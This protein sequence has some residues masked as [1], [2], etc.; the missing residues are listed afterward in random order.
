MEY[1]NITLNFWYHNQNTIITT[2]ITI[3]LP[4]L[5]ALIIYLIKRG[6]TKNLIKKLLKED[7]DDLKKYLQS[8]KEI[9][10]LKNTPTDD[11][12]STSN[13]INLITMIFE[14]KLN[15]IDLIK[16]L[17]KYKVN[18][19]KLLET[20]YLLLDK[21]VKEKLEGNIININQSLNLLNEIKPS[22]TFEKYIRQDIKGINQDVENV[23][24]LKRNLENITKD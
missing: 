21:K 18:I 6:K 22:D 5:V 24:K 11:I 14:T 8:L 9:D 3:I 10:E 19:K 1:L 20:H 4:L 12:N 7:K 23:K 2:A 17:E 15:A 16:T 13:N